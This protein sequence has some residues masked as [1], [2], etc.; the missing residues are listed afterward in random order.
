MQNHS[1]ENL[2]FH[3]Q[4]I[5]IN[6]SVPYIYAKHKQML[7]FSCSSQISCCFGNSISIGHNFL[8]YY[9][10]IKNYKILYCIIIES[11]TRHRTKKKKEAFRF[12]KRVQL[13]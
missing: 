2:A 9:Q 8:F 12:G 13:A 7:I 1:F 3:I 5:F 10:I 4:T 6:V 11:K